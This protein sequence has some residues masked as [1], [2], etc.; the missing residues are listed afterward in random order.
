MVEKVDWSETCYTCKH[1]HRGLFMPG[2]TS[3]YLCS[4]DK[5]DRK[6]GKHLIRNKHA[7]PYRPYKLPKRDP[8]HQ[9]CPLYE[10]KE[11]TTREQST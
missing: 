8:A 11:N 9:K 2:S 5:A 6:E 7:E 4:N 3:P 10:P 1:G